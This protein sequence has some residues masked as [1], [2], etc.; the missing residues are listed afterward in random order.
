MVLAMF[1]DADRVDLLTALAGGS[2]LVPPS[3]IAPGEA[4]PFAQQPTAEFAMGAYYLQQW[5]A[6]PVEAVRF[7]RR[8]AFY[9]AAGAAWHPTTLSLAELRQ[10]A[11]FADPA[12]WRRPAAIDPTFRIKPIG[13][14][15]A[16]C[17]AVAV[18]RGLALWSDDAAIIALLAV[19]HPAHPVERISDL[20]ARA[21]QEG[22]A[23]LRAGSRPLQPRVQ[24]QAGALDHHHPLLPGQPDHC[25]IVTI[26][27]GDYSCVIAPPTP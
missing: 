10:A 6:R 12:T 1:V 9:F 21:V 17:A 23:R 2:L 25:S 11:A 15:E 22:L 4:P 7:R 26:A 24:G 13:R 27:R 8:M 19:L 5:I 14:G 16:E 18:A 3:I 20:L